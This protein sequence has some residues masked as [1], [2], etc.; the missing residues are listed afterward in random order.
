[1]SEWIY[2][3]GSL[4]A[5]AESTSRSADCCPA[6]AAGLKRVD[7][8]TLF[9][10][11]EFLVAAATLVGYLVL[12]GVYRSWAWYKDEPGA[13]SGQSDGFPSDYRVSTERGRRDFTIYTRT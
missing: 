10:F 13:D 12:A 2:L 7:M 6:S 3:A 5:A 1:M 4:K 11:W 8:M 9:F